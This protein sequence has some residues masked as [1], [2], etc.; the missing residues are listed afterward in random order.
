M[1]EKDIKKLTKER[2]DIEIKA[3]EIFTKIKGN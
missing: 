3:T 1:L 2:E